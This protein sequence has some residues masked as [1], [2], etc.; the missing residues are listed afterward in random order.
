[1][2]RRSGHTAVCVAADRPPPHA[3]VPPLLRGQV[4]QLGYGQA[5]RPPTLT[6]S[7]VLSN[8]HVPTPLRRQQSI[9]DWQRDTTPPCEAAPPPP[10][11]KTWRRTRGPNM[12]VA[13]P[14]GPA[15]RSH[16]TCS[17]MSGLPGRV[18]P[19]CVNPWRPSMS[20]RQPAYASTCHPVYASPR[21]PFVRSPCVRS[22]GVPAGR[23]NP[24]MTQPPRPG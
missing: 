7:G 3:V 13:G 2:I 22:R 16:P 10:V 1:M 11:R 12:A 20:P 9:V 8:R 19:S 6:L 5:A 23:H 14:A 18:N 24:A 17:R 21:R 4:R 15:I